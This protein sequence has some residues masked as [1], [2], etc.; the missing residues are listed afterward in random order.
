ME[1]DDFFYEFQEKETDTVYQGQE[2]EMMVDDEKD[3][4]EV[5][6]DGNLIFQETDVYSEDELKGL[7]LDAF[8]VIKSEPEGL[9]EIDFPESNSDRY[10]EDIGEE[11]EFDDDDPDYQ[12]R[13]YSKGGEFMTTDDREFVGDYHM[14]PQFGPVIGKFARRD[15]IL[16]SDIL[17]EMEDDDIIQ[18]RKKG[19]EPATIIDYTVDADFEM[20]DMDDIDY[21][22][23]DG[24]DS[25]D[26]Y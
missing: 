9:D 18:I 8:E 15:K 10:K 11:Q 23:E 7:F 26:F 25:G 22:E 17:L 6:L 14:H 4:G 13:L 16:K 2:I 1:R 5:Y 12:P 20:D 19:K 3:L 24:V 21:R